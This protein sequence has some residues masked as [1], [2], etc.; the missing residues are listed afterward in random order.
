MVRTTAFLLSLGVALL[1]SG[2]TIGTKAHPI[3]R[4]ELEQKI[5]SSLTKNVGQKP[6]D[7]SCP[8]ELPAKKG[9]TVRCVLTAGNDKLG[10]TVRTT[11]VSD[12]GR[13]RFQYQVDKRM[14][15]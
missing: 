10:V 13:V 8:H 9:A 4:H 5:S 1:I 12:T 14:M 7:V 3:G 11:S 2:C 15:N 6:D